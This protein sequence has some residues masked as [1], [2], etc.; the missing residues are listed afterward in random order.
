MIADCNKVIS[1]HKPPPTIKKSSTENTRVQLSVNKTF[2]CANLILKILTLTGF[3]TFSTQSIA[4]QVIFF[5]YTFLTDC[6]D[7]IDDS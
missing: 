7:F 5:V 6:Y 1:I 2:K 3:L 4:L